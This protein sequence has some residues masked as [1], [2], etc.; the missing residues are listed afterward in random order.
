MFIL[1]I[2]EYLQP[3]RR[4]LKLQATSCTASLLHERRPSGSDTGSLPGVEHVERIY[5]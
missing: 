4:Y 5:G 2:A 1:L 3:L